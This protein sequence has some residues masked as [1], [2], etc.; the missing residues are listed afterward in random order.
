M[1]PKQTQEAAVAC[2]HCGGAIKRGATICKHC[3]QEVQ[4][5]ASKSSNAPATP[6][7]S[8]NQ[9][10]NQ[11]TLNLVLVA[12]TVLLLLIGSNIKEEYCPEFEMWGS[13]VPNK[14]SQFWAPKLYF[15]MALAVVFALIATS[16]PRLADHQ[17]L[18]VSPHGLFRQNRLLVRT[19][20][21]GA[22]LCCLSYIGLGYSPGRSGIGLH[23]LNWGDCVVETYRVPL[24]SLVVSCGSSALLLAFAG[25][26][27]WRAGNV[28]RASEVEL[29]APLVLERLTS[30][31]LRLDTEL[32]GAQSYVATLKQ[33]DITAGLQDA[34]TTVA[35]L[36]ERIRVELASGTQASVGRIQSELATKR[37]SLL[38][39]RKNKADHAAVDALRAD[40]RRLRDE[41]KELTATRSGPP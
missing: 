4:S 14:D 11:H 18:E 39:L 8:H 36:L 7:Y 31:R 15:A 6:T 9:A 41:L 35:K 40:I 12:A 20:F 34:E 16:R 26:N 33:N 3:K 19:F 24:F 28:F 10:S 5:G 23:T 13:F 22:I 30:D 27:N 25:L 32:K 37:E 2:P 29:L 38:I 1:T 17:P 21:V